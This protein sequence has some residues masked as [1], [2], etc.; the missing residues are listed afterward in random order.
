MKAAPPGL[1]LPATSP[2]PPAAALPAPAVEGAS[3]MPLAACCCFTV[4]TGRACKKIDD[5][6]TRLPSSGTVFMNSRH[7]PEI[8]RSNM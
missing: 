7:C 8:Y 5:H 4:L 3:D 1:V 2:L 6:S